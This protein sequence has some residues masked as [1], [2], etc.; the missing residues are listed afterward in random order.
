MNNLLNGVF[1]EPVDLHLRSE[2]AVDT[3]PSHRQLQGGQFNTT[4]C[5]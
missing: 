2:I 3:T 4:T 5:R 1:G